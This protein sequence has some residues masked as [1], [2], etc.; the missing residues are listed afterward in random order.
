MPRNLQKLSTALILLFFAQSLCLSQSMAMGSADKKVRLLFPVEKGSELDLLAGLVSSPK[1]YTLEGKSYILAAEF[2]DAVVAFRLGNSIQS[3]LKL[4]FILAYDLGHPQSDFAWLQAEINSGKQPARTALENKNISKLPPSSYPK[5]ESSS[6]S[7]KNKINDQASVVTPKVR[8][9]SKADDCIPVNKCLSA[10]KIFNPLLS[11]QPTVELSKNRS[12][13]GSKPQSFTGNVAKP[14]IKNPYL[15][16]PALATPFVSTTSL[17]KPGARSST[18]SQSNSPVAA[19]SNS[20]ANGQS[21]L[22]GSS[23]SL[24]K[25]FQKPSLQRQ[26]NVSSSVATEQVERKPFGLNASINQTVRPSYIA[27]FVSD[28][29]RIPLSQVSA[30]AFSDPGLVYVFVRLSDVRQIPSLVKIKSPQA[31]YRV[32][33]DLYAQVAVYNS[34]RLGRK[35][36]DDGLNTLVAQGLSPMALTSR[37]FLTMAS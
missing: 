4:P 18:R 25:T 28:Q 3:R 20:D 30:F 35:A 10:M 5:A 2:E 11:V 7:L 31:F 12:D 27:A 37:Q 22:L 14:S 6:I 16:T 26:S 17:Q 29:N 36:L 8:L 19:K 24:A 23:A 21:P 15:A 32:K 9:L 1:L 34:S 33:E 13:S